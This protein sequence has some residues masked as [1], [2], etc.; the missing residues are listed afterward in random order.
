MTEVPLGEPELFD[1]LRRFVQIRWL[2]LVAMAIGIVGGVHVLHIGFPIERAGAVGAAVLA[3]NVAFFIYH[4]Q[5]GA[6]PSPPA[7]HI[8]TGLQVGLDLLALTALIHF[9]GGAENPFICFYLFHAIIGTVLLHRSAAWLLGCAAFALFFLLVVLEYQGILPH[10]HLTGLSVLSGVSDEC[11]HRYA[12]YVTVVLLTFLVTLFSTISITSSVVNG[13]R[14]REQKLVVVQDALIKNSRALELANATLVEKQRQLV[15][16]EKQAALGQLVAGIAH[17][18]N[19][20]IQFIH[21]NLAVL[22]EACS[23]ALALLDEVAAARPDLRIAR[24]EYRF[25]RSQ[26][27]VLLK[28]LTDGAARIRTIVRDLKTFARSDEGRL[29]EEVDVN[30]AVHA[31]V[32]LLHNQLKRFALEEELEPQLPRLRG[33]LTHIEQV[34][35]NTLQNA[36]QAL[37][38]DERGRIRIRTGV[39]PDGERVR[40]SIQDNGP[41]I[42]PEVRD[43][44]FDPFFTTRQRSGG[45]GLGLAIT[46]GIIQQHQGHIEV[47]SEV[48]KGTTFHYVLP[49]KRDGAA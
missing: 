34:V 12:P 37:D 24:L 27:P 32:R 6:V 14:L 33:N 30:E 31:S 46:Y 48:G 25:F 41:G 21:G 8:E 9:T 45:T 16:S 35:V 47:E 3:Y 26:V 49:V 23:D 38:G 43:R 1:H 29:D 4:W 2:L 13:M 10:H 15:Q 22:S 19:N 36:A 17:E 18:I 28:D 5:R 11:R 40:L 42:P 39:E 20:P 7:S 44:I